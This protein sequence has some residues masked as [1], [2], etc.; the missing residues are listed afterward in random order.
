MELPGR[1]KRGRPQ[2]M[3]GCSEE[4]HAEGWCEMGGDG[5]LDDS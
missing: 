5:A 3:N 4:G 2:K 1:T